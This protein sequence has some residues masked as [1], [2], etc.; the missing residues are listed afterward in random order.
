[1]IHLLYQKQAAFS[2]GSCS[3][4]RHLGHLDGMNWEPHHGK[5]KSV[6]TA[7]EKRLPK[8]E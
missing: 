7:T 2:K 4:P 8:K 6:P 1:M 3:A 5:S